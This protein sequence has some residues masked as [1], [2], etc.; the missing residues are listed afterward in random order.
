MKPLILIVLDGWGINPRKQGN[1]QLLAKTPFIDRIFREYPHTKL[2]TSGL[3]VGLPEGQMGNSEVGHLTMGAGRI[4]Y[5]ELTRIDHEI[6]LGDFFKNKTLL[7]AIAA[8]KKSGGALQLMGLVSDG[9]VHSHINH[10]FA[11]LDMAKQQG[12]NNVFIHAFLDGRDTPPAGGKGYIENLQAQ[13]DKIGIGRIAAITGRYYAMDR[14][15]RWERVEKAYKALTH[16]NGR[17][18][19][20]PIEAVAE[21]YQNGETDEFILPTVITSNNKPTAVIKD[22]DGIIF[23]NFRAD[24]ARELTRAFTQEDF[25]GFNRG[26]K[27]KLAR[28]VCLT[29]Y[30]ATFNLPVAFAPQSLK[31]ILAEILSK[32]KIKQLRIAETEKYAHVTFFFNGGVEK[33]FPLEERILIPSPKEVPTYDKKPEMSAYPVTDELIKRIQSGDYQFILVNYANGDMVGHTGIMEAAIKACEVINECLEKVIA[34]A[35]ETGWVALIT[36]DHGNIEQMIDYNTH[37]VHTAHTTNLVPFVLIDNERK[38][39]SLREGGLS[40]VAPTILD[41]MG[42][43]KPGEMRGESLIIDKE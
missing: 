40:D 35:R 8:I 18:S 26:R 14:D 23:F 30:D 15:N 24:R 10:L 42:I 28:Y 34:A 33:P 39:V 3:S 1:A 25:K 38:A 37:D 5:Q 21:A 7:D 32:N 22:G 13:L 41:L 9:G 6:E 11:L 4:V 16:G 27:I 2:K 31:N 29:E 43:E 12:L 20:N 17:L 36:S 19:K